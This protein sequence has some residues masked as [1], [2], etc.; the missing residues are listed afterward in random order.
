[1]KSF[2]AGAKRLHTAYGFSFLYADRLSPQLVRSAIEAWPADGT[3]GWP[4]WAFSNHDAPRA[5]SRWAGP[6]DRSA[7]ARAAMLL[8]VSLRGNIF[9]Y[10]GEELG[11]PQATLAFADL[12]DPEAITNWPRSLGRDGARTPMPWAAHAPNAG[13]SSA[14]PW[15]PMAGAIP[16][17]AA[18]GRSA[19]HTP[20]LQSPCNLRCRPLLR[21]QTN[22]H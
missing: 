1:M 12:K 10:Q 5:V 4:S 20:E 15:L 14:R 2:T 21:R 8:L 19:E 3:T 7:C 22:R 16:P 11:L 18:S 17:P 6:A 9:L 13:F